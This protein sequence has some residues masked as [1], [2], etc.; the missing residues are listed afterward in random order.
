MIKK[1]LLLT[2]ATS[3]MFWAGCAKT[4]LGDPAALPGFGEELCRPTDT[5]PAPKF[6]NGDVVRYK[7]LKEDIRGIVMQCDYKYIPRLNTYYCIVDFYP[8]S[9]IHI[10]FSK[11]DNYE[12]RY[13]Y[14]YELV[15]ET[16]NVP[17][18][19]SWMYEY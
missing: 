7:M 15:K 12:R 5:C 1:I 16:R 19:W 18:R 2:I 4:K 11:F 8:S 13:V 9:A 17:A 10:D 14:E 6:Q 3:I